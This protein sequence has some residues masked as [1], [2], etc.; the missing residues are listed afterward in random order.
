MVTKE[1]LAT[2]YYG[3]TLHCTLRHECKR[4]IG[5]RGGET[6]SIDHVRTSGRLQTWKR[7]QSRFRQPIKYGLYESLEITDRNA[8]SFHLESDC[9]ISKE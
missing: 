6:I 7:D 4:V 5:P 1:Q 9:P 3:Q 2:L 8:D